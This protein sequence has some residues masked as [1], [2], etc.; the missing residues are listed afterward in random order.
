LLAVLPFV[1]GLNTSFGHSLLSQMGIAAVF[2]LSY[3]LLLGQTG[4]LSFGHAVYFGLG[5]YV[6]IHALRLINGGLPIPVMVV[7]L[8]GALGGLVSGLVIGAVTTRRAGTVF[9]MISLGQAELVV[10]ASLIVTVFFGGEEGITANRTKGPVLLGLNLASQIQV[11]YVVLFW[12]VLSAVALAAFMHTPLGRLCNAVRDN[13]ERVEFI[14]Y[15]PQR[16]R[17]IAFAVSAVFAGV[18]GGLHAVNYEIV[19]SEALG[20]LRS[21]NVLLMTYIGGVGHF[22]GP[23]IGAAVIT[24]LQVSLSDYTSAWQLYLGLLF[25]LMVLFAPGGLSGLAVAHAPLVRARTLHKVL[26]AYGVALPPA[27]V[28]AFG[29]TLLLELAYRTATQPE[30][31][32]KVTVFWMRLDAYQPWPWA[33]GGGLA[34][35]GFWLFRLAWPVVARSWEAATAPLIKP[36]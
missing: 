28:T 19:A 35:A 1:P 29:G 17:W 34:I 32:G 27:L 10:A 18:A 16:V 7:P 26:A 21:G 8:F 31:G 5:G 2:A 13:P 24:W 36:E 25:I 30:L 3:N 23:V 6:A 11:Y 12:A 33:L 15:N 4:L 14:G 20:A 9:A 22:F